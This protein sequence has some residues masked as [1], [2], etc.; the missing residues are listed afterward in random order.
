MCRPASMSGYDQSLSHTH[1]Y[2]PSC[3]LEMR[4]NSIG[5]RQ[6]VCFKHI[7][8]LQSGKAIKIIQPL[9]EECFCKHQTATH[10]TEWTKLF[11]FLAVAS[12]N[13]WS[14]Y[15]ELDEIPRLF[16]DISQW[17]KAFL[18]FDL[19][20]SGTIDANELR[21][22]KAFISGN[23]IKKNTC[24]II[25]FSVDHDNVI[26]W[27]YFPRYWPLWGESTC[28]QW[29]PITKPQTW[30]FD[31]FFH[32]S[33]NKLLRKQSIWLYSETPW[34]SLWRHCN[35]YKNSCIV[36]NMEGMTIFIHET[37]M[38]L[39]HTLGHVHIDKFNDTYII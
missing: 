15:L 16:L 14:G 8:L 31:G 28:H 27:K 18:R 32:V 10:T 33:L 29:I 36:S 2:V 30:S 25:T 9:C 7:I 20:N 19:D 17:Q 23:W 24:K 12:D 4:A 37:Q 26:K 34:H 1:L 5:A 39:Y 3:A 11:L 21:N 38:H 13:N 6:M 35:V 22:D